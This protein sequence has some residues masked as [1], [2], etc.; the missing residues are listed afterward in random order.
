MQHLSSQEAEDLYRDILYDDN[1]W[2]ETTVVIGDNGRLIDNF[3]N[4]IIFGSDAIIVART[5]PESGFKEEV[6]FSVRTT[7]NM[8]DNNPE[9]G[10]AVAGEIDVSLLDPKSDIPRMGVIIPYVRACTEQDT[11]SAAVVSDHIIVPSGYLENDLLVL[12]NAKLANDFVVFEGEKETI[13]SEWIQ[14]G[15]YYIDSRTIT[16]NDDGLD[17]MDI[18]GFDAMLKAEQDYAT[19]MQDWPEQGALDTDIVAEIASMMGVQVDPRTW[20]IMNEGYRLPLPTN[21]SCREILGYIA[22]MYLGSFI[23]SD[24]GELRLVSLLELPAETRYLVDENYDVI[25]FGED[26]ICV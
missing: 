26:R 21:Y 1:H 14:Q 4:V 13:A 5:G 20:T 15:V 19:T 23:M 24:I 16:H 6:L 17:I 9:V 2:F 10:K 8:F 11:E 7:T 25:V 3:R 22:S 12:P 18:H